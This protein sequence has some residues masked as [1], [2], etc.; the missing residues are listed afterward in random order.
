[1]Q[2]NFEHLSALIQKQE[3]FQALLTGLRSSKHIHLRGSAGSFPALLA[4]LTFREL[5]Q[6]LLFIANSRLEAEQLREDLQLIN[7]GIKPGLLSA[8]MEEPYSV[9]TIPPD[10]ISQRLE[11]VQSMYGAEPWLMVTSPEALFERLPDKTDFLCTLLV[12]ATGHVIRY[13]DLLRSLAEAGFE[14]M[15]LVEQVGEF[16]VRGDIIDFYPWNSA[17]PVRLEFFGERIESLRTFDVISQRSL[18]QL[19]Q[20]EILPNLSGLTGGA[21]LP[22]VLPG[23]ALVFFTD[24]AVIRSRYDEFMAMAADRYESLSADK[25]DL[26][27]PEQLFMAEETLNRFLTITPSLSCDLIADTTDLPVDFGA[28]PHPDF[29]GS[30]RRFIE[31]L[32]KLEPKVQIQIQSAHRD[33]SNRLKNIIEEEELAVSAEFTVGSLHGGFEIPALYQIVLTDH[34]IFERFKR[35]KVQS[36]FRSGSYLRQLGNLN[37]FDH[38]VHIDYGIGQYLGMT[39]L[40]YGQVKKECIKIGYREGDHLFVTVDRLNRVQKFGSEQGGPVQL[41]KLRSGEWER[42]TTKTRE[43]VRKIAAELIQIY[44]ARKA[45]PGYGFAPDTHLQKELEAAFPY[46]ET[47]DQHRSILEVKRDMEKDEPM[48]RLLCGDVGFGKT[49][50]AIRAAFKAVND[51]KQVA[52]LAPTTILAFQHNETFRERMSE[53]PV[54]I[55]MINRFKTAREQKQIVEELAAGKVDIIIATHRLLSSDI[56]FK[57]LGLLIIDEEQRF[58]VQQKEILKKMR[59]SVDILAMTATPIPRT[60]HMALMGARDLSHIETAP[61]NRRP[62]YTEILHWDDEK[63]AAIIRRELDRGGQVYFV[64]NRVETISGVRDALQTIVPAAKIVIGHG[65]LPERQLEAVML[66]FMHGKYDILLASMIIENG[67]DIPNVNTII[68]NR[69]DKFGLSQL[70][71]LRGR[72][73]RSDQQAYAYLVVPPLEK[74]TSI[75]RQR[76]RA[77]QDF[78]ELG[79]GFKIA[80]RDLEIRGAGD[81]LGR[82]QSGFVQSVGFE[83]YTRILE[84]AVLDMK[85]GIQIEAPE[86]GPAKS[87]RTDPKVDVDFDLLIPAE[88]IRSELERISIYHRLVN[89]HSEEQVNGLLDELKDRFGTVPEIVRLF[90]LTMQIKIIASRILAGRIILKEGLL[91]I[92]FDP[93]ARQDERF[94]GTLMPAIMNNREAVM[95][96]LNQ[97]ELGFQFRLSGE[98][99]MQQLEF[100]KKV[101]HPIAELT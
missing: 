101:L 84:E 31:Y 92:I 97:D 68:I 58:G 14:R 46:E 43:S 42:T 96:F 56:Q 60:L 12:L 54:R 7:P 87:R 67:L 79:S 48:D 20:I 69:A 82:D 5:H 80:L 85:Q 72:V 27:A 81:L 71:Q 66:N 62:V 13:D 15:D 61:R 6:P 91:K 26:A 44:A 8:S 65:Q 94:F 9:H 24:R 70:Y 64:H 90:L 36:R 34:E 76:L 41:T 63:L 39:T 95:R 50:V 51:G 49:E 59:L 1:M 35:R 99:R 19:D 83:M 37:L 10:L 73:G 45:Q 98:N 16:S 89:F 25:P 74:L 22:D 100:A 33:Q 47:P 17:D 38:V 53:F 57:N 3:S 78:T 23:Q 18:K 86:T 88:Y 40:E 11:A 4:A 32:S 55:E 21:W 30:I 75:S 93:A 29:G 77:I 52:L 28:R 2:T